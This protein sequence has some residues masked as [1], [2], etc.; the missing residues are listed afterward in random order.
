MG[1]DLQAKLVK[2]L[3]SLK[4]SK[5]ISSHKYNHQLDVLAEITWVAG[6]PCEV[7]RT[8]GDRSL[9]EIPLG[10]LFG[11]S[12]S[13]SDS[14]GLKN[15][16]EEHL[17]AV[18][19][20][21]DL[22]RLTTNA[23]TILKEAINGELASLFSQSTHSFSGDTWREGFMEDYFVED[24]NPI[25]FFVGCLKKFGPVEDKYDNAVFIW[26]N[27]EFSKTRFKLFGFDDGSGMILGKANRLAQLLNEN[28][29]NHLV[30]LDFEDWWI[31]ETKARLSEIIASSKI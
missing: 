2:A 23:E 7:I 15:G 12:R 4:L 10:E 14:Q 11:I 6:F 25:V 22:R 19:D 24:G 1:H 3:D 29:K 5:K 21:L 28:S 27:N 30:P 20:A 18:L 13:V 9:E 26:A 17:R 8:R 31:E 16:S